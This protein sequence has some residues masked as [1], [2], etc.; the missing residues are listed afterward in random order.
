MAACAECGMLALYKQHTG[1]YRP[2]DLSTR[3]TG[4]T[5][6]GQGWEIAVL[7]CSANQADLM[8]EIERIP[9][10]SGVTELR[11]MRSHRW[12][13]VLQ[14]ARTA[15][16][17]EGEF[18]SWTP[19]LT[20]KDHWDI[21]MIREQRKWQEEQRRSDRF[22]HVIEVAVIILVT[23]LAA[24]IQRGIWALPSVAT[25]QAVISPSVP[26]TPSSP[27]PTTSAASP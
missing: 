14:A 12:P 3:R 6:I 23:V 13:I 26:D 25:P 27:K 15:C 11:E 1:E 2:A 21:K 9:P 16:E 20:I 18:V 8:Q 5:Q 10:P 7:R 17:R 4:H 19:S 24:F 22:W